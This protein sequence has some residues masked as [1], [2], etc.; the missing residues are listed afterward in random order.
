MTFVNFKIYRET[1]ESRR[2]H[3]DEMALELQK[4]TDELRTMEL[5]AEAR[6]E[7]VR[8][9]H[10]EETQRLRL[11][12]RDAESQAKQQL[13]EVGLT[14]SACVCCHYNTVDTD[15]KIFGF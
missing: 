15:I 3:I 10:D 2:V 7:E 6:A 11:Q 9:Q 13:A 1:A 5:E 8:L 14:N 4:K 12:L